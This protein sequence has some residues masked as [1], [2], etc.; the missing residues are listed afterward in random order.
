MSGARPLPVLPAFRSA[1]PWLLA[2]LLAVWALGA[3]YALGQATLVATYAVA[4]LGL[5]RIAKPIYQQFANH[6]PT[7]IVITAMYVVVNLLLTWLA[8][9]VQKK[10]VG[11]KKILQVSMV[12]EQTAEAKPPA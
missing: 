6:V 8:Y 5:T 12:G 11:E 2:V 4:G 3:D 1:A 7:I 9:W 10:F